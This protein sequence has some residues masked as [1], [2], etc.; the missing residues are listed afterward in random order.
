[1]CSVTCVESAVRQPPT[2]PPQAGTVGVI[3]LLVKLRIPEAVEANSIAFSITL[4]ANGVTGKDRNDRILHELACLWCGLL[5]GSRSPHAS[6][7]SNFYLNEP[8]SWLGE[9][10]GARLSQPL[11]SFRRLKTAVRNILRNIDKKSVDTLVFSKRFLY[12]IQYWFF[13][14]RR[15]Q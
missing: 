9:P 4:Q 7:Y 1:V 8:Q 11:S 14:P 2:L 3:S 10:R 5:S 13:P 12:A 6:N 15:I